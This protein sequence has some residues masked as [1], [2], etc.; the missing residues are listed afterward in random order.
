MVCIYTM[1][2]YSAIKRQTNAIRGNM[3][4]TRDSHTKWSKPERKRQV[5]YDSN[6]LW[7]LKYGTDDPIQ[8]KK[9][10][11]ETDHGQ[12]DQTWGSWGKRGLSGMDGHLRGFLDADCCIWNGWAVEPYCTAQGNVCD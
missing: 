9:K 11:T 5:P 7:K 6:F 12:E 4:R 8:K 2:Y 1:E 10:E 3:D